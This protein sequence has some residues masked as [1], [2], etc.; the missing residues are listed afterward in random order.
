M[1]WQKVVQALDD[2]WDA[3]KRLADFAADPKEHDK[4]ALLSNIAAMLRDALAR[5]LR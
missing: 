2:E 1:D 3:R 5:G 4:Q